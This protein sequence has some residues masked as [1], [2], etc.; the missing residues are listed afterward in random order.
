MVRRQENPQHPYSSRAHRDIYEATRTAPDMKK[1]MSAGE[2]V[3]GPG[4]PWGLYEKW[5]LFLAGKGGW[6]EPKRKMGKRPC[7]EKEIDALGNHGALI[8]GRR[9]L[10]VQGGYLVRRWKRQQI[11]GVERGRSG[12]D[13]FPQARSSFSPYMYTENFWVSYIARDQFIIIIPTPPK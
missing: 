5:S 6:V 10:C 8:N 7:S 1:M 4:G 11:N 13:F 3:L 9:I 2:K 12:L